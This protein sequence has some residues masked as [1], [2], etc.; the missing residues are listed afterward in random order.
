MNRPSSR[1]CRSPK[2]ERDEF[3][4]DDRKMADL[5]KGAWETTKDILKTIVGALIGRLP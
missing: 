2:N 3:V 4:C 5:Q 1:T